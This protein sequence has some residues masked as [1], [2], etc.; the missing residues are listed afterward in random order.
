MLDFKITCIVNLKLSILCEY[1]NNVVSSV[2]LSWTWIG[3]FTY[4]D[5]EQYALLIRKIPV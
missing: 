5:L 4:A 1:K 3:F 2:S